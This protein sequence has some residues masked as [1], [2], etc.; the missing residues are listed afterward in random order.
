[1]NFTSEMLGAMK[2]TLRDWKAIILLGIILCIASTSRKFIQM[3]ILQPS[4]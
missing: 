4:S 1:M 3:I 2:Y